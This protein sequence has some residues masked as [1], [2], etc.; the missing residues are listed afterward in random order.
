[1][2]SYGKDESPGESPFLAISGAVP[3]LL[4]AGS[5]PA[6]STQG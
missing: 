5:I 6:T 3:K 2:V 1:M 4:D